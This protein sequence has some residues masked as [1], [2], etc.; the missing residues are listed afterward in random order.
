[1][2]IQLWE[3]KMNIQLKLFLHVLVVLQ[4]QAR[5]VFLIFN[6]RKV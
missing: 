2:N 3:T 4:Q 5:A 6:I 1:M